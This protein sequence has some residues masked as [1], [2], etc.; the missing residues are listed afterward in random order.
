MEYVAASREGFGACDEVGAKRNEDDNK[1]EEE[2]K[3][4]RFG[5]EL[6]NN[7]L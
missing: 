4:L 3:R 2:D 1:E 7:K 5:A 6:D